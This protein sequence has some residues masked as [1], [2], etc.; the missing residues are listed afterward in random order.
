VYAPFVAGQLT[1]LADMGSLNAGNVT[2]H[3][4][5]N[6]FLA[7]GDVCMTVKFGPGTWYGSWNGGSGVTGFTANGTIAGANFASSGVDA[8]DVGVESKYSSISGTVNGSFYGPQAA[9][10]G[11]VVDITKTAS[12]YVSSQE[13]TVQTSTRYVD[14]FLANKVSQ[15]SGTPKPQ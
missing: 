7:G 13:R 12:N 15:T 8:R 5:G 4:S 14:V 3:Y 6:T 2:A 9:A 10:A 1:S 11:G